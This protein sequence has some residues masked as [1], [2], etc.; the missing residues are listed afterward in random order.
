MRVS[1]LLI[2]LITLTI[3]SEIATKKSSRD[4]KSEHSDK[5]KLRKFEENYHSKAYKKKGKEK[6]RESRHSESNELNSSK[7]AKNGHIKH[8]TS[9]ENETPIIKVKRSR[10]LE[11]Q[12]V[13]VNI[14]KSKE[15]GKAGKQKRDTYNLKNVKVSKQDSLPN[16]KKDKVKI[17]S[18]YSEEANDDSSSAEQDVGKKAKPKVTKKKLQNCSKSEKSREIREDKCVK[19]GEGKN[20]KEKKVTKKKNTSLETDEESTEGVN[21]ATK[22]IEDNSSNNSED[23]SN[24]KTEANVKSEKKFKLSSRRNKEKCSCDLEPAK[25]DEEVDDELSGN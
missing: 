20:K 24:E 7:K 1:L 11:E 8:E 3:V 6:A 4:V 2:F 12:P 9:A 13:E 22:K 5:E 14:K 25:H 16:K 18:K 15:T 17:K 21:E 19:C 10:D 23:E